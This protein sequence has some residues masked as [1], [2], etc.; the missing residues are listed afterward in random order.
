MAKILGSEAKIGIKI[1]VTHGTAVDVAGANGLAFDS[2]E[3]NDNPETLEFSTKG[4]GRSMKSY[5]QL[6]RLSPTLTLNYKLKYGGVGQALLANFWGLDTTP[7]ETTAS[8]GDYT[9]EYFYSSTARFFT[10]A[11]QSSTSTSLEWASC[12][13]SSVNLTYESF[14]PV[15][16]SIN[17]VTT[18]RV[19]TPATNT[20][21]NLNSVT[22]SDQDDSWLIFNQTSR[23]SALAILAGTPSSHSYDVQSININLEKNWEVTNEV[24]GTAVTGA[25]NR[26]G[27][28]MCTM[29]MTHSGL[30]DHSFFTLYENQTPRAIGIRVEGAQI[31]AGANESMTFFLPS[32]K[33][34]ADPVAPINSDGFN[35]FTTN[36]EAYIEPN[37]LTYKEPFIGIRHRDSARY[38]S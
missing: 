31:G 1:G 21:A 8:Q 37:N 35:S 33:L 27:L 28:F 36:W 23:I 5:L 24:T 18:P 12:Y 34:I 25:P 15:S 22:I 19:N 17:F 26:T 4:L 14:Q 30:V 38:T 16:V 9:R 7:S 2:L 6:G 32:A 29:D 11:V 20:Y 10:I 3:Y 13:P